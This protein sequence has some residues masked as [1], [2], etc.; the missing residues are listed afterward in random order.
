MRASDVLKLP[1]LRKI[2]C[3]SSRPTIVNSEI[4]RYIKLTVLSSVKVDR[5]LELK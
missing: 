5:K 4:V 3:I 2:S 1:N